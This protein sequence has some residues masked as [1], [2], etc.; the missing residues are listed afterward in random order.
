ML[1]C[2]LR[3][4]LAADGVLLLL[5]NPAECCQLCSLLGSLSAVI[6]QR[7]SNLTGTHT[8]STAGSTCCSASCTGRAYWLDSGC[9][10]SCCTS[11]SHTST[12]AS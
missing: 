1:S 8:A 2:K 5:H 3:A 4:Y 6:M 11:A 7:V 9:P 10:C 12:A